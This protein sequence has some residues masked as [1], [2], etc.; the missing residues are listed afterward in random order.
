MS[1]VITRKHGESFRIGDNV[2][3]TIEHTTNARAKVVIDA[4][5]EVRIIRTELEHRENNG[6][7][8]SDP[9][10]PG[11]CDG[12]GIRRNPHRTVLGR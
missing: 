8:T 12:F 11:D 10:T 7:P 6:R 9:G 4:P 3:V 5:R 1:L 2:V